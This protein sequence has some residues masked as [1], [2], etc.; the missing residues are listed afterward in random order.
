MKRKHSITPRLDHIAHF[1]VHDCSNCKLMIGLLVI[2]GHFLLVLPSCVAKNLWLVGVF[3]EH[4]DTLGNF[5]WEGQ[6]E[7]VMG[8]AANVK[9]MSLEIEPIETPGFWYK[10]YPK[11]LSIYHP[12]LAIWLVLLYLPCS[13]GGEVSRGSFPVKNFLV[14]HFWRG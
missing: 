4:Q 10:C 6:E 13:G 5:G 12:L 14:W 9:N 3:D 1:I 8:Q 11:E 7:Y 2:D